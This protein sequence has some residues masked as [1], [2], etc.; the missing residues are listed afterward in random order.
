MNPA[1]AICGPVKLT[2]FFI[3]YVPHG[4]RVDV[5]VKSRKSSRK[6]IIGTIN[7]QYLGTA[8]FLSS[9]IFF[10]IRQTERAVRGLRAVVH[11]PNSITS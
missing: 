9:T 6:N 11:I 1:N 2:F 4:C 10:L 5:Y 7:V 8:I 3:F